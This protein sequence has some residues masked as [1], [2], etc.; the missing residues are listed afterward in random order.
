MLFRS[1]SV[2][3]VATRLLGGIKPNYWGRYFSGVDYGGAGE[4]FGSREH[5]TLRRNNIRVLP[6]A[7]YTTQVGK[8][9]AEGARDGFDQANDFVKS[10]GETYL[11]SQGRE[12]YLF[13]DVEPSNPLS[14][15]YY[16]GW[17]QAVA[18]ISRRVDILPCVYL[19]PAD[20]T[21][22]DSLR[23]AMNNGSECH[24]LWIASYIASRSPSIPLP[25]QDFDDTIASRV[26]SVN[27]PVLFWQY[28]GD[29][30]PSEDFDFNVGNPAISNEQIL[31]RLILPPDV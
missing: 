19:N 9:E 14:S 24:G 25:P 6:V 29:I 7:R 18:K 2:V 16:K 12:Y 1:D 20:S 17:S 31:S 8:G 13:L 5:Q 28:A 11:E 21:T 23:R 10:F 22:I 3:D 26:G 15:P 4:Y 30:G 27:A